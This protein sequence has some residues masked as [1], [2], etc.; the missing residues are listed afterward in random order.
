LA[1]EIGFYLQIF[2]F[3]FY[4]YI[5]YYFDEGNRITRKIGGVSKLSYIIEWVRS[6]WRRKSWRP[7]GESGE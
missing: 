5:F 7:F 6:G 3:Y 4:I 1:P 2:Y